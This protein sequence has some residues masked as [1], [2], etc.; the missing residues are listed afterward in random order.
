MN[1]GEVNGIPLN[2]HKRGR[3]VPAIID[4]ISLGFRV[5]PVQEA[6]RRTLRK[7]RLE[8]S[9]ADRKISGIVYNVFRNQGLLEKIAYDLTGL[10]LEKLPDY[11]KASLLL[12]TYVYHIDEKISSSYRRTIKRYTIKYLAGKI[13]RD[14]LDNVVNAVNKITKE[15][16]MPRSLDDVIMQRY[17]V[18]PELYR[19]L[20]ES[21][22]EINE[23]LEAFLEYTLNPPPR[24]FR[25]NTL[26]ASPKAIINFL[27]Q[28]GVK[29]EPGR[30]SKRTIRV[31][32]SLTRD[33][34][35]FIESG[36]LVPQ[37]ESSTIAVELLDPKPGSEIADL[38]AAPGGKT[39]L[40]AEITQLKSKIYSFEIFKDRA[41]RLRLL[42]ERTGTSKAVTI[43]V[44]DA[45]KAP[46]ILGEEAV[47]YVL[48]DPPC[49]STGALARNPDVRWRFRLEDAEKLVKLQTELLE[50]AWKILRRNGRMM[51]TVCSV[52][53]MEGEYIIKKFVDRRP[54]AKL[55]SLEKPFSKSPIL[56]ETMRAWPHRHG[57]IGF[58]YA[59]IEKTDRG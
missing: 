7:H 49:T 2:R 6:I 51:Y 24:V 5:K 3:E 34:I 54:D 28:G 50:S 43:Y 55:L 9:S 20:E 25:V 36:I 42:L 17:K 22:K 53:P 33:I 47:D 27:A 8:G 26:K 29:I 32:G 45:R 15:K 13:T 1:H 14:L 41:R 58:F 21:F 12:I 35:R 16:W 56:E 44:E 23:D 37:D 48:L 39:T 30:Y 19:V 59:L 52:L 31:H 4:S 10:E 38:C 18:S 11:I 57:V 40:L 46:E